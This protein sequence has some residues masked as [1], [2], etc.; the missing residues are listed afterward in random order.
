M[1]LEQ[2]FPEPSVA[3]LSA[4]TFQ[5]DLFVAKLQPDAQRDQ[6]VE[7]HW[8]VVNWFAHQDNQRQLEPDVEREESS[9]ERLARLMVL[10]PDNQLNKEAFF[11]VG[12]KKNVY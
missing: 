12:T 6:N 7:K 3:L 11:L 10:A 4:P 1:M 2:Q 8:R 9:R 5:L